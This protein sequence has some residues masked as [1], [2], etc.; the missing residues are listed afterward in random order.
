MATQTHTSTA[1]HAHLPVNGGVATW[2]PAPEKKA[3]ANTIIAE[4]TKAKPPT[5]VHLF[6]GGLGGMMGACVT[7]PMEVVKTRLQSTKY[8]FAS[9][10]HLGVL[11]FL[12]EVYHKEGFRALY[13][14][15]TPALIGIIPARSCYFMIY[16]RSKHEFTHLNGGKDSPFIHMAG[17]S[18]SGFTTNTLTNPLWVVK[19]RMQLSTT[20]LKT[21]NT[22]TA[23]RMIASAKEIYTERGVKGFYR[24]LTAS[25]AGISETIV[26][27]VIY[28]KLKKIIAGYNESRGLDE[29]SKSN[30]AVQTVG[31]AASAK[32]IACLLTYPHE[33]I[34]TRMR[35]PPSFF[36]PISYRKFFPALIGTARYEGIPGLY[37]G[38]TAH[39]CRVLPNTAIMFTCY[40][41][42]VRAWERRHL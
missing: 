38:L 25:Y 29:H 36:Y 13:K 12:K 30:V 39:L 5:S 32:L 22:S 7:N 4:R 20:K 26:Q 31:A 41:L 27:F 18:M 9:G 6:A 11:P 33:V 2:S 1:T 14:G 35:E 3:T 15:L 40:E 34:R 10:K 17:A 24:G 8:N 42:T 16:Q 19:T 28:E 37:S 21:K 23:H